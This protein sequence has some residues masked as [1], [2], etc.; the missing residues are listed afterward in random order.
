MQFEFYYA[1]AIAEI[2]VFRRSYDEEVYA[3]VFCVKLSPCLKTYC[4]YYCIFVKFEVFLLCVCNINDVT[5][6]F[7]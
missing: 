3:F 5:I 1:T 4:C 6:N 7:L 2:I